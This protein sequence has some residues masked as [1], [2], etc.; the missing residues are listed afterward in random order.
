MPEKRIVALVADLPEPEAVVLPPGDLIAAPALAEGPASPSFGGTSSAPRFPGKSKPGHGGGS[1]GRPAAHTATP[2]TLPSLV[3][4]P[5]PTYPPAA[6]A[7]RQ[8]GVASVRCA[9]RPD[10]S[11]AET[12]LQRGTGFEMLDDAAVKAARRWR[13]SPPTGLPEGSTISVVVT[14]TFTL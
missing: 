8:N 2:S 13:F 7:A 11:V 9:V 12:G 4:A 14:V 10:G 5:P 1:D 6:R 3:S